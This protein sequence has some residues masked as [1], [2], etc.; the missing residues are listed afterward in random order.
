M[1]SFDD[2]PLAFWTSTVSAADATVDRDE[3]DNDRASCRLRLREAGWVMRDWDAWMMRRAETRNAIKARIL[4]LRLARGGRH[5]GLLPST[6]KFAAYLDGADGWLF[7]DECNDARPEEMESRR[8]NV[9]SRTEEMCTSYYAAG[10]EYVLE[11]DREMEEGA[12]A[13]AAERTTAEGG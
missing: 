3:D 13:A 1:H 11:K 4:K 7:S 6:D 2:L 5:G 10:R 12:R 8:D 9:R